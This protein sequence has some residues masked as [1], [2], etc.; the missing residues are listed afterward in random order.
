MAMCEAL[1]DEYHLPK[2]QFVFETRAGFMLQIKKDDLRGP[3]YNTADHPDGLPK[4][5][6]NIV[7]FFFFSYSWKLWLA[8]SS[9]SFRLLFR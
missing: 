1:K 4:F 7:G 6:T 8:H 3:S 9:K 5:F 2:L